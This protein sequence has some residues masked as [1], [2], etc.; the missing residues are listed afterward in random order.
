MSFKITV[1][2]DGHT[3]QELT[4]LIHQ[5]ANRYSALFASGLPSKGEGQYVENAA[6]L[7]Q[8][9]QQL[10]VQNRLL[11]AQLESQQKGL[12]SVPAA[13]DL[14][15]QTV[16]AASSEQPALPAR[17]RTS[18]AQ[19]RTQWVKRAA[20]GS[21]RLIIWLWGGRDWLLI[22]ALL[23]GGIFGAIWIAPQLSSW[24]HSPEFVESADGGP[25]EAVSTE[26][27]P[28]ETTNAEPAPTTQ[29]A[30]PASKA[31]SNPPPP[32]AFQTQ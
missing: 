29:P 26:E 32:P 25:G 28:P 23:L 30:D 17:Y 21:W 7:Q 16:A 5:L 1:E 11:Q 18:P 14:L 10:V 12:P 4:P 6:L 8:Q 19:K 20:T 3:K 15:P 22:V 2:L 9:I 27:P 31:G 13:K 24:L